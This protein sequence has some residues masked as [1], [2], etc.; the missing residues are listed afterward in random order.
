MKKIMFPLIVLFTLAFSAFGQ[1][2]P[3][4][5]GDPEV[6]KTKSQFKTASPTVKANTWLAQLL[7]IRVDGKR[8][9]EQIAVINEIVPYVT[10]DL[11]DRKTTLPEGL[12]ERAKTAF[13]EEKWLLSDLG[14]DAKLYLASRTSLLNLT[15]ASASLVPW[16]VCAV[17]WGCAY[18]NAQCYSVYEYGICM[19]DLSGGCGFLYLS[20]CVGTCPSKGR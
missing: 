13:T 3:A 4:T 16:C 10:A 18:Q 2:A 8:T 5:C 9:P 20:P 17:S 12:E 14:E 11:F 1:Q 6:A 7:T 19:A 15:T